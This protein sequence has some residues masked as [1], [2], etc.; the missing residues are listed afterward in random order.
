MSLLCASIAMFCYSNATGQSFSGGDGTVSNPYLITTKAQLLTVKNFSS[1]N[2]KLMNDID[3][4]GDPPYGA[5]IITTMN[6]NFNGAGFTVSNI[7]FE[8]GAIA[9]FGTIESTSTVGNLHLSNITYTHNEYSNATA[10]A[11]NQNHA[12]FAFTNNGMVANSSFRSSLGVGAYVNVAGF[13]LNNNGS[14][15]NCYVNSDVTTIASYNNSWTWFAGRNATGF[16]LNN[17][18]SGI[19]ENC[20]FAG[21]VNTGDYSTGGFVGSNAGT[22]KNSFSLATSVVSPEYG[23]AVHRFANSNSGS[24]INNYA[25]AEMT[26]NGTPINS[27]DAS[28]I[29]AKDINGVVLNQMAAYTE[30]GW[31]FINIWK[32]EEGAT[33]PTIRRGDIT[34]PVTFGSIECIIKDGQLRLKWLTVAEINCD[35]YKVEASSDGKEF[36]S[37]AT[38]ASKA[39]KGNSSATLEYEYI[40][41]LN[42]VVF[43]ISLFAFVICF[44]IPSTNIQVS[45]LRK[46]FFI[47][48]LILITSG[49]YSCSKNETTLATKND[50]VFIRIAQVDVDGSVNYSK[51]I[52]AIVQ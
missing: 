46:L 14:I 2:Y 27:S 16:V 49:I 33:L 21:A 18:S 35:Y 12:P 44:L 20:Y 10:R 37:I 23:S 28:S 13:I 42:N 36:I 11:Q 40:T 52:T 7:T 24:L 15:K 3:F 41:A 45:F 5:S 34:L 29:E 4:N 26:L 31:D 1:M 19:I 22:I 25:R 43:G 47:S 51:V 32:F 38:I 6:G 8:G 50:K 17:N 48:G 30:Q 39:V 9:F